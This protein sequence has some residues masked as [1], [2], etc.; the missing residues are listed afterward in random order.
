M[1][2]A[3]KKQWIKE[4]T[5]QWDYRDPSVKQKPIGNTQTPYVNIQT[6]KVTLAL[7]D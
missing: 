7:D 1:T 2:L 4:A 6:R 3:Q 5:K